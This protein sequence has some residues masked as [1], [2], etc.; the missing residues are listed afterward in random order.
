ME[1]SLQENVHLL[2]IYVIECVEVQEAAVV[3]MYLRDILGGWVTSSA[4]IFLTRL[5]AGSCSSQNA[6]SGSGAP[7][8]SS[9]WNIILHSKQHPFVCL[10]NLLSSWT[11]LWHHSNIVP[12]GVFSYLFSVPLEQTFVAAPLGGLHA[13]LP[14]KGLYLSISRNSQSLVHNLVCNRIYKCLTRQ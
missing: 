4:L 8:Y 12:L 10:T 9:T 3:R 1:R 14:I 7:W 13:Q 11:F 5:C 6:S 2:R